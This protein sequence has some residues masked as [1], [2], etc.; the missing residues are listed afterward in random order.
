MNE[1]ITSEPKVLDYQYVKRPL[2][3]Y[4]YAIRNQFCASYMATCNGRNPNG[5]FR[6]RLFLDD[7]LI[8]GKTAEE[9]DDRLRMVLRRLRHL[10]LRLKREKC[11]FRQTRVEYL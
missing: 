8:V 2:C 6:S 3:I 9:H 5:N 10:G 1:S 11:E 4:S 7:I